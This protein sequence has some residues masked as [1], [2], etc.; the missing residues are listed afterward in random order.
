MTDLS[1]YFAYPGDLA[2]L[3]GGYHYDRRL[4]D[5]LRKSGVKVNTLPLPFHSTLQDEANQSAHNTIHQLLGELPEQSVVM[6]DGLAFGTMIEKPIK[7][8]RRGG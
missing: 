7:N 2:T 4:I 1:I 5:E 8:P 6:I 3:S